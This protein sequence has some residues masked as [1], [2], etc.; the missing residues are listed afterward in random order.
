MVQLVFPDIKRVIG[1]KFEGKYE[2]KEDIKKVTK[3]NIQVLSNVNYY[4]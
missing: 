3:R 4:R 1:D 2:S